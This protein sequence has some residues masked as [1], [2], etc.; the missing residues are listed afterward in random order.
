[1]T[2]LRVRTYVVLDRAVEEGVAYGWRRAHKYTEAPGEDV[3][4]EEIAR[5]VMSAVCDVFDFDT[6]VDDVDPK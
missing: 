2:G 5:A 4:C 6:E 3:I 1:M